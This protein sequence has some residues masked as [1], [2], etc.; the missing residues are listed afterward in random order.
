MRKGLEIMDCCWICGKKARD[1]SVSC[2]RLAC[3]MELDVLHAD[4]INADE[5]AIRRSMW[6]SMFA[7]MSTRRSFAERWFYTVKLWI[8]GL[9]GWRSHLDYKQNPVDVGKQTARHIYNRS[10]SPVRVPQVDEFLQHGM[11][12]QR[13]PNTADS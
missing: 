12:I 7:F 1:D 9:F 10:P 6:N 8:C 13:F 2:G 3:L 4:E 11:P 5:R